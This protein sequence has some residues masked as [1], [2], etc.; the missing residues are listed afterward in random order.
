M[1]LLLRVPRSS[2]HESEVSEF[3]EEDIYGKHISIDSLAHSIELA[4]CR[5]AAYRPG[6]DVVY[7][8]VF[9]GKNHPNRSR[10]MFKVPGGQEIDAL[11]DYRKTQMAEVSKEL[12]KM[13]EGL[14][15]EVAKKV[16]EHLSKK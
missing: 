13:F 6:G 4:S 9:H 2:G 12:A 8:L 3:G 14:A 11:S 7:A 15:E 10:F 1:V 16:I 5:D